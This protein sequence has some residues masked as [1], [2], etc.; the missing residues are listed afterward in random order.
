[1]VRCHVLVAVALG[2]SVI[3]RG[4]A[5]SQ[6]TSTESSK[7]VYVWYPQ[8]NDVPKS[9]DAPETIVL[10]SV[11]E[12][13]STEKRLVMAGET[14][15]FVIRNKYFVSE[16]RPVAYALYLNRIKE[17]NPQVSDVNKLAPGVTLTLP[18]GPIFG[19][20]EIRTRNPAQDVLKKN[21]EKLSGAAYFGVLNQSKVH[22]DALAQKINRSLAYAFQKTS[23][24]INV[25]D[26]VKQVK[27]LGVVPAVS[28]VS[29]GDT[30]LLQAQPLRLTVSS[31]LKDQAS[32]KALVA[33][34]KKGQL[35]PSAISEV[36]SVPGIDC[37]KTCTSCLEILGLAPT[38]DFSRARVLLSDTG[39]T[40]SNGAQPSANFVRTYV[41]TDVNDVSSEHH[42]TFVFNEI[43]KSGNGPIPDNQIYVARVSAGSSSASQFDIG[44]ILQSWSNFLPANAPDGS[45]P[46]N[47]WVANLSAEGGANPGTTPEPSV[48]YGPHLLIIAAAGNNKSSYLT[49]GDIFPRLSNQNYNLLIVGALAQD[50]TK[51][52]YS[53]FNG[54]NVQLFAR[55]NC[56]CGA[57]GQLN[58]TS[59]AAP[60]VTVAAA[61]LS[62]AKPDW[63]ATDVMWRLLS[64]ADREGIDH[65]YALAGIVNLGRALA[66]GI[67]VR[68]DDE[69]ANVV[70]EDIGSRVAFDQEW[71]DAIKKAQ[72]ALDPNFL[73][74]RLT[75][76]TMSVGQVCFSALRYLQF[77]TASV[78]V[79]Q[80]ASMTLSTI[81]G[82]TKTVLAKDLRDVILPM[83]RS[84]QNAPPIVVAGNY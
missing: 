39:V 11:L 26:L 43:A 25:D 72:G 80:N 7:Y 33:N 24:P 64:T 27:F 40:F 71:T 47:T 4:E 69:S 38:F 52:D 55:G 12:L 60:L 56:V 5:L 50:G 22:T 28:V 81:G 53:N 83:D 42:G 45:A 65:T 59:Q 58:G 9:D 30:A 1:M 17:L 48:P 74:L 10:R 62:S 34:E 75:D 20:S 37:K 3:G 13:I 36:T 15:N 21:F 14:L 41:G 2:L 49:A 61:A 31:S 77:Q 35:L 70:H 82:G 51:A 66:A 79:S 32:L 6:A 46:S 57:P 63:Y 78:C 73:L 8:T 16:N 84:S 68:S 67:V 18:T 23:S 19:A 54:T 76:R 29:H 44:S